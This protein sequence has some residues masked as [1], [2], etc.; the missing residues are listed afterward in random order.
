MGQNSLASYL[1][2]SRCQFYF[3][4]SHVLESLPKDLRT[5]PEAIKRL[6]FIMS[7]HGQSLLP[8]AYVAAR[9]RRSADAG[10]ND[11]VCEPHDMLFPDFSVDRSEW[12]K[13][14][15]KDLDGLLTRSVGHENV[16]RQMRAKFIK[17]GNLTDLAFEY[18]RSNVD[19]I[20][21]GVGKSFPQSLP[22]LARGGL[23]DFLQ[24]R[25]SEQVFR[26]RF[27]EALCSPVS[28][29]SM[30]DMPGMESIMNV[31]RVFWG[32]SE[33]MT[34][35]L[36]RLI[37][38][39]NVRQAAEGFARYS[40]LKREARVALS[41]ESFASA[42]VRKFVSLEVSAAQLSK[43]PGARMFAAAF[44]QLVM[45]KIDRYSNIASP[46]FARELTLKRG[47]I[48][49][50]THL[51]YCPYVDVFGC[52]R[53]MQNRLKAAKCP[54]ENVVVSDLEVRERIDALLLKR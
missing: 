41:S 9:E 36:S 54:I 10:I 12:L 4:A 52:D 31:S 32:L 29:A 53:D 6:E 33:E 17:R 48:A 5:N 13:V 21:D 7:P 42:S 27:L 50:L 44:A 43:M 49:D 14:I 34:E 3:S 22:L 51:F 19:K 39:L 8:W 15:R 11:L 20:G 24:R 35:I 47:D 2:D 25:V 23:Y 16:R 18:L 37:P 30:M 45:E 28:L 46:E 26:K 1:A 40:Q 38:G